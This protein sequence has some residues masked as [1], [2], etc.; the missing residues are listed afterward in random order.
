MKPL[1]VTAAWTKVVSSISPDAA[2]V[3]VESD[4][5]HEISAILITQGVHI[6]PEVVVLVE[7]IH[8]VDNA[9]GLC[10]GDLFSHQPRVQAQPGSGMCFVKWYSCSACSRLMCLER[11]EDVGKSTRLP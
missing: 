4:Q 5:L 10:V 9:V 1:R 11:P 2:C 8:G 7:V 6:Y 3:G